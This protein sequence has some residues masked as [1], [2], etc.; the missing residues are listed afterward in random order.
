[1]RQLCQCPHGIKQPHPACQVGY[2]LRSQNTKSDLT[3]KKGHKINTHM[4]R[5][6]MY[7]TSFLRIP[8]SL[9]KCKQYFEHSNGLILM[10][11]KHLHTHS[12]FVLHL[13]FLQCQAKR[14]NYLRLV[15]SK[16]YLRQLSPS[17]SQILEPRTLFL[18]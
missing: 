7:L 17:Q 16:S 15:I 4:I 2:Q 6:I 9:T 5:Q 3:V 18:T 12:T 14:S 8:Y 13:E 11:T 1:M 10:I